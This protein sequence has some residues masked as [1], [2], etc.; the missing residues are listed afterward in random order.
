MEKIPVEVL[1]DIC[2]VFD[3]RV[4][5]K[6]LR[7]VNKKFADI[8]ASSLFKTL[9]VFQHSS[10]WR[11]VELI[12]H[13]PWLA[14][15]VKKLEVVPLVDGNSA[16]L[17]IEWKQKSRSHRVQ[18]HLK[19]GNRG[20]AVAELVEPFDDKLAAVLRLQKRYQTW[21]LWVKGQ[22]AI[23]GTATHFK[24][25]GL[26]SPLPFPTLSELEIA[27]PSDLWMTR[28]H[29]GR[30][31][32][33]G[34]FRPG[35]ILSPANQRCN[36]QLTF[37]LLVLHDSELKIT[38]LEL[39][40]YRDVLIDQIHPVQVLIYLKHLKLH[41]R[42]RYLAVFD[43]NALAN[44][45]ETEPYQMKL[46][47]FLANAEI[48]ESL[49]L[50]LNHFVDRYNDRHGPDDECRWL[51]IVPI[52]STAS[53]PKLRSVWLHGVFTRSPHLMQFLMTYGKSLHSIHLD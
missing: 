31:E 33:S 2:N 30:R 52:F 47:P 37:T 4:T 5:L 9:V 15:L 49:V 20:T 28:L 14:H 29:R 11:R 50:S 21:L 1:E 10:S 24:N 19:L 34:N 48:L 32:R 44:G 17:F 22:E 12:A 35:D 39:H 36:A 51:D 27:W 46:A 8:A 16:G 43:A 13:R 18:C 41:F 53:W 25:Q 7:L 3:D 45:E 40:Q 38:R 23:E 6:A 26:P 42:H